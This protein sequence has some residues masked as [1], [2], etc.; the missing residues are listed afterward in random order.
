[1]KKSLF[2]ILLLMSLILV[3]CSKDNSIKDDNQ[4]IKDNRNVII[5]DENQPDEELPIEKP[6]EIDYSNYNNKLELHLKECY[7]KKYNP[8]SENQDPNSVVI[9]YVNGIYNNSV[10]ALI[11]PFTT[12]RPLETIVEIDGVS[13]NYSSSLQLSVFNNSEFYS[14]EEAF[15]KGIL[16]HDDLVNIASKQLN[17]LKNK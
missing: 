10:V 16:S 7:I 6:E 17:Y 1:M 2:L 4:L 3:G 5:V 13:F 8:Y 11:C 12:F 15:E 14:I 9:F